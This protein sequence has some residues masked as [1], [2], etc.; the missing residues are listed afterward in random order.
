MD[1]TGIIYAPGG[2]VKMSS[3]SNSS[4]N[5]SIIALATDLS[6]SSMSLVYDSDLGE[7]IPRIGL[8]E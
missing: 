4:L 8:R 3:A 6:G 1:W 7:D 2:R 5:G